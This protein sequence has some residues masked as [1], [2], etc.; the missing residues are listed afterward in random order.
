MIPCAQYSTRAQDC[1]RRLCINLRY[2]GHTTGKEVS[3][4]E[5][6]NVTCDVCSC[7]YNQNGCTC[8]LDAIKITE[9]CDGC[10]QNVDNPHYC[11]SYRQR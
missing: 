7:A 6:T 9:H 4:M 8:N 10:N 3:K 2:K 1:A 11:Q 5:N